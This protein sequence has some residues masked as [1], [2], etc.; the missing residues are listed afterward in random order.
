MKEKIYTIPINEAFDENCNCP[1]CFIEKRLEN[2]A[3]EYELGPAMM[4]PDHREITNSKGFCTK[5]WEML[6][7]IPQKLPLALVADTH[8]EE[9]RKKLKLL[10]NTKTGGIFGKNKKS[11]TADINSC[12]VCDKVDKTMERY[13]GVLIKMWNDDEDFREKFQNSHGFCLKHFER[14]YSMSNNKKFTEALVQKEEEELEKLQAD[15]HKFTLMFDYRS[16]GMEWGTAKDAPI[17][18]VEKLAG[19]IK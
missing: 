6:Y 14:L 9:I 15:I 8:L 18:C 3:I 1:M 17:R 16:E 4:E 7:A 5:H 10:E 13:C 2:E 19:Y 12:A 11:M